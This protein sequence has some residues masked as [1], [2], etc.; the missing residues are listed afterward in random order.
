MLCSLVSV[1]EEHSSLDWH[2]GRC[3]PTS[4][5]VAIHLKE[6]HHCIAAQGPAEVCAAS[7]ALKVTPLVYH[8]G[9]TPLYAQQDITPMGKSR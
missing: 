7:K 1:E 9:F 3:M 2:A 4:S 5:R 8:N 6:A